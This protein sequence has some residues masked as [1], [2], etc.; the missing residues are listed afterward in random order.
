MTA[1]AHTFHRYADVEAALADPHLVPA[2]AEDGP[3]GT[4]AWLR[5]R[6]ARF[7]SGA[8]H[9]RR[10][11]LVEAELARLDPVALRRA[12]A[13][14]DPGAAGADP[15][16][17]AVRALA[18]GI[19]LAEPDAVAAAVATVAR[20]YFGTD[21]PA[22]RA[23]A[24]AAVAWLLPRVLDPAQAPEAQGEAAANRI[25]LLVQACDATGALVE[26]A[27]KAAA[28]PVQ[29]AALLAETLR[30]DPPVRT[31]RRVAAR[32]TRVAG[33]D[34]AEGDL[35][36]LDIAAANRDPEVFS[37]PDAF[38]P[39]RSA[40]PALTFGAAP[41]VCPGRAHALALAAGLLESS[42]GSRARRQGAN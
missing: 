26:H 30:H 22:T 41:R 29:A 36:L 37:A 4:T 17:R 1:S 42:K 7:S 35:V 40:P 20:A 33:V 38:D 39:Q 11:A 9:A 5:A 13:E 21:D 18:E 25:G 2:P 31:M 32:A 6:V 10:R 34:I 28:E 16:L 23:S 8:A 27:E 15:R 24:D 3:P 14:S 12:A 19:G